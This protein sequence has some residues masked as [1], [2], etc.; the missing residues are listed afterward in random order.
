MKLFAFVCIAFAFL[1]LVTSTQAKTISLQV[2]L[3]FDKA[4][5]VS[6]F[7]TELWKA[8]L[9]A[10]LNLK[11]CAFDFA[12]TADIST[13]IYWDPKP[14]L[15]IDITENSISVEF[16]TGKIKSVDF[17]VYWKPSDK[18]NAQSLED[19]IK[20]IEKNINGT[21]LRY[22]QIRELDA[23]LLKAEASCTSSSECLS[24]NCEL[25]VCSSQARYAARNAATQGN[26]SYIVI[27]IA[28]VVAAV[29]G[30]AF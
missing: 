27:A 5:Q 9:A 1:G 2:T 21:K 17:A 16:E 28:M 13:Q 30:I 15:D 3:D 4:E 23:P 12:S 19:M 6:K 20:E 11:A 14:K 25:Q 7:V 24:N 22:A 18:C 10:A 26:T 8:S 29:V